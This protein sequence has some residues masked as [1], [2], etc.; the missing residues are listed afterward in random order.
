MM[1]MKRNSEKKSKNA[2]KGVVAYATVMRTIAQV[3]HCI[4][5][6]SEFAAEAVD[7]T[8]DV[9]AMKKLYSV[10]LTVEN[11]ED[12][13]DQIVRENFTD[14]FP[15]MPFPMDKPE[16]K[17]PRRRSKKSKRAKPPMPEG[18]GNGTDAMRF[19]PRF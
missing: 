2:Y 6:F 13:V 3:L 19:L 16:K 8:C 12:V 10:L 7:A 9:T 14:A 18:N 1:M 15:G 4:S 17:P 5:E 11:S